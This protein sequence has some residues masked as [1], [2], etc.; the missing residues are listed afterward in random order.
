MGLLRNIKNKYHENAVQ[1]L[2]DTQHMGVV[3]PKW[4]K[5]KRKKQSMDDYKYDEFSID[6]DPTA[7]HIRTSKY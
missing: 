2:H 1:P 7:E 4:I 5:A 3:W 6:W